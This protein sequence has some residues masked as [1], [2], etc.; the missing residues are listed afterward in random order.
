[1]ST[2][3]RISSWFIPLLVFLFII[4]L[5]ACANE[6]P[7]PDESSPGTPAVAEEVTEE[8]AEEPIATPQPFNQAPIGLQ[9]KSAPSPAI[10]PA[11]LAGGEGFQLLSAPPPAAGLEPGVGQ[12]F[13][14]TGA[15]EGATVVFTLV[16]PNGKERSE[17]VASI[18]QADTTIAPFSVRLL[19]DDAPGAWTL[20]ASSGD[21]STMQAELT[22]DVQAPTRPFITLLEPIDNNTNVIRAGI[23]GLLPESTARFAL[24]TLDA[25]NVGENGEIENKANLLISTRLVADS[26]GRA[27]LEL[28]VADLPAGPYLLLLIPPDADLGSPPILRL[29]DQ[30]RLAITANLTRSEV[31]AA[32]EG[33]SEVIAEEGVTEST[34]ATGAAEPPSS[35][36][37]SMTPKLLETTSG[38]PPRLQL[39]LPV[40]ELPSCL[41]T[42]TPTLQIW[43]TTGE[44]GDWW[45]GCATGFA[46]GKD[47]E[48]IVTLPSGE[49]TQFNLE[50]D[51]NGTTPFRWYAAP[52]EGAGQY[53]VI[54]KND[55]GQAELAWDIAEAS[56]P[57]ILVF[58][59][60]FQ[61]KVGGELYLSGFPAQQD[62]K[63]GLFQIDEQGQARKV[64]QWK[65]TATKSGYYGARFSQTENLKQGH[66]VLIAQSKPAFQFPG[67]DT[68]ASAIE[69]FSFNT[70]PK[71]SNDAYTLFLDR[72]AETLI[73]AQPT[74]EPEPTPAPEEQPVEVAEEP[75]A[76]PVETTADSETAEASETPAAPAEETPVAE[77]SADTAVVEVP[78][79]TYSVPEDAGETPSCP[80]ETPGEPAVCILPATMQQGTFAYIL[81]HDFKP[82]T[83][84]NVTITAPNGKKEALARR[85]ADADGF[86]DAYWYALHGEPLGE[87]KINIRGGGENFSGNLTIVE[88]TSPHLVIQPRSPKAGSNLTASV[89]GFDANEDLLF[90]FYQSESV[91][92][93]NVNFK[94]VGTDNIQTNG[95]GGATKQFRTA[96]KQ[97]GVLFL[98]LVYRSEQSEPAAQAVYQPGK[99]LHL[100]Y[101]LA[102]GQN[103]QE[104]Q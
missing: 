62:V 99:S 50:A 83:K 76:T 10:D 5:A 36:G 32:A 88:P 82:R 16:D 66:Y 26:T 46:S 8:V 56:K 58:P 1:M 23:G 60:N 71:S 31:A 34:S 77:T 29:P 104:G 30:E 63:I 19:A 84:F 15:P 65:V 94:L 27:D 45:Y 54:A 89:T 17:E 101:P 64:K 42:S 97:K 20:S 39:N 98:I 7:A 93:G 44:I 33:V 12:L 102:W 74:A 90:A 52:G 87:Y 91:E 92:D 75:A 13:C 69:F 47:V 41:T 2:R 78:P 80:G 73:A 25:A 79:P 81:M 43:P 38:V 70:A 103:Y 95:K 4:I 51:A 49:Q 40:T 67:V 86:A 96:R 55:A 3:K 18:A 57:H 68:P 14:A 21:D 37:Q 24:Y 61:S 48:F 59:H 35:E 72:P 100:Q 85:T 28:D 11:C 6:E 22:F 53:K 9:V